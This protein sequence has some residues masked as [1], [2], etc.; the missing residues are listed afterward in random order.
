M[1]T[2]MEMKVEE[3]EKK[4]KQILPAKSSILLFSYKY[5]KTMVL[6]RGPYGPWGSMQY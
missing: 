2:T 6:N 4:W 3:K 1:M 5:A